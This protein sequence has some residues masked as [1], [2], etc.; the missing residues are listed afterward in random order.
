M[1]KMNEK[2][3]LKMTRFANYASFVVMIQ[4]LRFMVQKTSMFSK[5]FN[6]GIFGQKF[7]EFHKNRKKVKISEIV[8]GMSSYA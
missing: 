7:L 2:H 8:Y 3:D 4:M 6:E 5:D 1:Q